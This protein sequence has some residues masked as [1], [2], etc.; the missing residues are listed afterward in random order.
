MFESI[1]DRDRINAPRCPP[2]RVVGLPL[3]DHAEGRAHVEQPH[4]A[5]IRVLG[6]WVWVHVRVCAEREMREVGEEF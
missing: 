5:C 3:E 2:R 1:E 6:V 4:L